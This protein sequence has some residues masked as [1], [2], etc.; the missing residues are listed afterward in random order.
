MDRDD[1]RDE[2]RKRPL[3]GEPSTFHARPTRALFSVRRAWRP[4]CSGARTWS[5]DWFAAWVARYGWSPQW[6]LF[7]DR[8]DFTEQA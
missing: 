4:E 2:T 7:D 8:C 5:A 3:G 1:R 6:R